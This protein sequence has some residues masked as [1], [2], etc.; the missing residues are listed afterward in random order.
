MVKGE[1]PLLS[2]G[3]SESY[4]TKLFSEISVKTEL[5]LDFQRSGNKLEEIPEEKSQK[6]I[7]L[8][9][10]KRKEIQEYIEERKDEIE[11][12][13]LIVYFQDE[14]HLNWGD[15]CGYV[16][17][18]TT[19]RVEIP[20]EN[21]KK[22]QTYFGVVDVLTKGVIVKEYESGNSENTINFLKYLKNLNPGKKIAIFW[23]GASYHCS[24]ETKKFLAEQNQ[25]LEEKEWNIYCN[26]L[27]P[28]A[29]E[30]NPIEDIWLQAK[31]CLREFWFLLKSFEDAK[32]LFQF[33]LNG[34]IFDLPKFSKYSSFGSI[35][36]KNDL[37]PI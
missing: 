25:G 12:G 6:K 32:Y 28:N 36:Q 5:L 13:E 17:G 16:W 20:I 3:S 4:R 2:G 29:P 37:V 9:E 33:F 11:A 8:V 14:C 19:E 31:N 10:N 1:R 35:E 22:R 30:Q 27:A 15:T 26:R 24:K 7:E 21:E 34:Q 23:D 18:K